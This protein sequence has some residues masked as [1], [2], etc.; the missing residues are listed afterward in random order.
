[1]PEAV[2]LQCG[3]VVI[4]TVCW[5]L[6][7]AGN[8]LFGDEAPQKVLAAASRYGL[9]CLTGEFT[10]A[11]PDRSIDFEI[12]T[13]LRVVSTGTMR[14]GDMNGI[15]VFLSED[16]KHIVLC[17][18]HVGVSIYDSQGTRLSHYDVNQILSRRERGTRPGTS[19]C[20]PEGVWC[21]ETEPVTF[22]GTN[23]ARVATHSGR[24]V[25]FDLQSGRLARID[26]E[27]T[28]ADDFR[29]WSYLMLAAVLSVI[30]LGVLGRN[31]IQLLRKGSSL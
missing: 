23:Y 31:Y 6:S 11:Y 1:M 5:L 29:Y 28:T 22:V 30:L 20:H 24:A 10:G 17:D 16:A 19:G 18:A 4:S 21:R 8:N 13:G 27:S 3:R 9:Y 14:V 15:Q 2:R 7:N 25:E 12:R 26:E